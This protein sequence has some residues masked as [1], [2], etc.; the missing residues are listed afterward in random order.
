[1][2]SHETLEKLAKNPDW[3]PPRSDL[4]V[5]LGQPGAP[6]ATKTTVEPGNVFSP[7]MFTFGVTWWLRFPDSGDFFATESA[8]LESLLWQYE[9]GFLPILHCRTRV[10]GLDVEHTL[11]QDGDYSNHD[12]AVAA[13]LAL[14]NA[15][16]RP[17]SVQVF[18]ALRSLG[19][20]GGPLKN[21]RTG[22]DHTSVWNGQRALPLLV[23]DIPAQTVGCGVGDPA[24]LARRD[25][26]R[27]T[28]RLKIH[29]AGATPA[30]ATT[31]PWVPGLPGRWPWIVPNKRMA[32][33]SMSCPV[34]R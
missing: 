6:E 3:L 13:R 31:W 12:E 7:G 27:P 32:T 21:L 25:S 26:F 20:A 18:V 22:A 1:M 30:C 19:P 11:F 2:A 34:V 8:P 17:V 10:N 24:P 23:V 15:S 4:R 14:K 29:P 33:W 16:S 28:S 5:F 9:E